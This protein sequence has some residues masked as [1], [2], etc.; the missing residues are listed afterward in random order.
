[1]A[2]KDTIELL[3]AAGELRSR[4]PSG[5]ALRQGSTLVET[6]G[7]CR[8][9]SC[10]RCIINS[11]NPPNS[12]LSHLQMWKQS[13]REV[14]ELKNNDTASEDADSGFELKSFKL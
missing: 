12:L 1:M 9:P 2:G 14:K 5:M 11:V 6:M 4:W 10:L 3:S 7:M 13:R 8:V